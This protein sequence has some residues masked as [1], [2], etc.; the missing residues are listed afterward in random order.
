MTKLYAMDLRPFQDGLWRKDLDT[1]PTE[2]KERALA[3]RKEDDG[4]RIACAGYLLQKILSKEG[5]DHPIFEKNEWGKPSLKDGSFHFSLSHSGL[6]GVCALSDTPVGVDIE[7]PRCFDKLAARY[8]SEAR[9]EDDVLRLWTAK[10]AYLKLLGRGLTVPLDS[11]TVQ[12]GEPLTLK[13]LPY[14]LHEYT[15][16]EYRVCLCT[17]DAKPKLLVTT[18]ENV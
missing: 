4:M 11:V 10:E 7:Q 1:L 3:C 13:D 16:G 9:T 8:F 14:L 6:W 12:L 5:I 15:L 2:R 17:E 18:Y